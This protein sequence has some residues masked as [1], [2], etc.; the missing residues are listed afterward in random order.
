MGAGVPA[1]RPHAG[2]RAAGPHAHRHG[3]RTAF[4][5]AQGRARGVG[6]RPG[7]PARR[8]RSTNPLRRTRRSISAL[9]SGASG[10][11]RTA[12][13]RAKLNDG[14]GR[15]DEVKII[16]RQ[17][18]PLSSGNHY[19]CRIAQ[20]D[21]GNLFVTLGE[22]F[23]RRD[24][25]QNLGNHLGKMIRIAP[26]GSVAAR[27]PVRRP[28]RRQTGDLELRPPQ[29]AERS[30]SIRRPANSGRSSTARAAATRST[31]SARARTTAGR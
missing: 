5:A 1:R 18:G 9:P 20:A 29:S 14:N 25:A 30:R 12:V 11:G 24:E 6:L 17:E 23:S 21:D 4:A 3:G 28:R 16:F 27:Q 22:H 31:S 8:R 10:G 26:D 13:A 19:G 15:L 2:D 7:R